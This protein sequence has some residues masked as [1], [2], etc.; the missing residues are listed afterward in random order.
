MIIIVP[1]SL[2]GERRITGDGAWKVLSVLNVD[3]ASKF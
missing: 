2:L 1:A 3:V